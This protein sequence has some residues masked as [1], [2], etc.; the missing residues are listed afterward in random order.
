MADGRP[1]PA[2]RVPLSLVSGGGG[3]LAITLRDGLVAGTGPAVPQDSPLPPRGP[4]AGPFYRELGRWL[5]AYLT[6]PF[7]GQLL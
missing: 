7:R 5:G 4:E 2:A 3:T 1:G 6:G